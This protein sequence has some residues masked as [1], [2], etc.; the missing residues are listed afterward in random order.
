MKVDLTNVQ[1]I[2]KF[3][4]QTTITKSGK[5]FKRQEFVVKASEYDELKIQAT[6]DKVDF[7]KG[8]NEGD[9]VDVSFF[10][11]GSK[12][13]DVWFTNLGMAYIKKLELAG[14][15][16]HASSSADNLPF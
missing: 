3:D 9:M 16:S 12:W 13:K 6:N 2:K 14:N 15:V 8:I 7:L 11:Q 1:V 10:V 4:A 5:D